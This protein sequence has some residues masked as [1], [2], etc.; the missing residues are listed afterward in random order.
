MGVKLWAYWGV[1]ILVKVAL[2]MGV[3]RGVKMGVDLGVQMGVKLE[4]NHTDTAEVVT[5][6][7][8]SDKIISQF[9]VFIIKVKLGVQL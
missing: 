5:W 1:K 4:V 3:K 9:S 8:I 6:N 7:L 2:K